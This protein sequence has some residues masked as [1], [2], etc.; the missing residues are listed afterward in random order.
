M[1]EPG[2]HDRLHVERSL[3]GLTERLAGHEAGLVVERGQRPAAR[4]D[5][6]RL[7]RGAIPDPLE[8]VLLDE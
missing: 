5:D 7:Q 6:A 1:A 8:G 2:A 3:D 4:L